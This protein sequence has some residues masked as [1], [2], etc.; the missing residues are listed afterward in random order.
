MGRIGSKP[1]A[2]PGRLVQ[3]HETAA[4]TMH[5]GIACDMTINNVAQNVFHQGFRYR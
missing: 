3:H 2:L 5:K 4:G 1:L